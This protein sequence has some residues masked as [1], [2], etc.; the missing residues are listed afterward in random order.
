MCIRDSPELARDSCQ[1]KKFGFSLDYW[2]VN[3]FSDKA[4]AAPAWEKAK[5]IVPKK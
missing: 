4:A 5:S 1:T 2:C 3:T